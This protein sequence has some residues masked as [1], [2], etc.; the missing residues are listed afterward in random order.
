MSHQKPWHTRVGAT[1][2]DGEVSASKMMYLLGCIVFL[3]MT[4][5]QAAHT[6][7]LPSLGHTVAIL[8]AVCFPKMWGQFLARGNW[9]AKTQDTTVTQTRVSDEDGAYDPTR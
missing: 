1:G 8:T 2:H 6:H 7:A 5:D 4:L 9:Q 3:L